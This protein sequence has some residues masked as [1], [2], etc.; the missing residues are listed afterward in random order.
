MA[1]VPQTLSMTA[2]RIRDESDFEIPRRDFLDEWTLSKT[3]G[4]FALVQEQPPQTGDLRYDAYLAALAEHLCRR[5]GIPCPDWMDKPGYVLDRAW[6]LTSVPDL[7][8]RAV[9]HS[10]VAFRRRLIF[11]DDTEFDRV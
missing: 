4:K 3:E 11:V 5:E 10:P 7:Y 1:Y 9:V 2:Q 6:F 8:P